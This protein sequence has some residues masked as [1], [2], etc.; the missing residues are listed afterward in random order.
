MSSVSQERFSGLA[1]IA[2]ENRTAMKLK[3]YAILGE[4]ANM[5]ARKV[6]LL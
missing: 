6:N 5:K 1:M 4:F 2:T 3:F